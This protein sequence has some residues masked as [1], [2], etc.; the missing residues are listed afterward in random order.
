MSAPMITKFLI[1]EQAAK[2]FILNKTNRWIP[3]VG[4][5]IAG[6]VVAS[7]LVFLLLTTSTMFSSTTMVSEET[8]AVLCQP[9]GNLTVGSLNQRLQGKGVF[10]GKAAILISAG[11]RNGVDPV[12]LTAIALHETGNG[13][14]NAVRTK[15]N[16]GGLMGKGGLMTFPSLEVGI[17]KMA[18]NL[19]EN[20][21]AQG[22]TTPETIQR[23]YAPIGAS[24][25]PNNL[26]S[27]WVAGVTKNI[28]L[29]G[30]LTYECATNT[31][32]MVNLPG[33]QFM[34]PLSQIRVT[35]SFNPNRFH[36]VL[37]KVRPHMG[38]DLAGAYG[39]PV[40]SARAGTVRFSGEMRG[41]GDIVILD[42]ENGLSTRY[43]H[44]SAR[45]VK[46]GQQVKMGQLIGKVGATGVATGPHLH[47][48]VRINEKSVDPMPYIKK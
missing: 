9:K 21:I 28:N 44:L 39:T 2:R 8:G 18:S 48:E 3:I 6:A 4:I 33:G 5:G 25:D 43:G 16:P 17:D 40:Y 30:G 14:S 42:H 1:A 45:S 38:V 20:Y 7:P 32:T 46:K 41:Y 11:E 36:P 23:K 15:N 19:G 26:N 10:E 35:S 22:L 29:L 34:Q 12:L 24:N 31:A 37:K 47:F 13:K 27:H